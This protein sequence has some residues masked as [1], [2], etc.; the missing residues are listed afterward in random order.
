MSSP[1]ENGWENDHLTSGMQEDTRNE[2]ESLFFWGG[3]TVLIT[4]AD[5]NHSDRKGE[6]KRTGIF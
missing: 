5:G 4:T 6:G 3:G 2:L 1:W